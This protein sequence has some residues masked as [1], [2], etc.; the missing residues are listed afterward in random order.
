MRDIQFPGRSVVHG[1]NGAAATSTPLATLTAIDTLRAGG[2]AVDAAIAACA[3]QCVAEPMSTG[4]GGDCFMLY[5][6][7]GAGPVAGFNGSGR[8]PAGLTAESLLDRGIGQIDPDG[9]ESVTVPGAVDAWCAIL[10]AH[11]TM[12]IDRVLQ[13]AIAC[14]EEGFTVGEV[15]RRLWAGR[16]DGLRGN[17]AAAALYLKDGALPETGDIWHSP[18]LGRTLRAIAERG[19]DGFYAGPVLD[20]MLAA[21][22]AAGGCHTEEDFAGQ[23]HEPVAPLE[24]GYRGRTVLE[25]PPNGGGITAQIML[26]ILEGFDLAAL[27]PVG[28]ERLHLEMEAQRLAYAQRD[29]FVGDPR[30]S[31]VPVE[32]LLSDDFAAGL[33]NGIRRDRAMDAP[34]PVEM[35][36]HRDTVYLTVVDRDL[37]CVS[38]IN[39]VYWSFGSCIASEE[40]GVVFQNRGAGFVVEP[41]HP[42][43]VGPRKRPLHTIIP[44]MVLNDGRCELAF[45][46]MGGPFQPVGQTHV[47][48]NL[49]DFGMDIQQAI[50]CP[51][52]F[53]DGG[54]IIAERGVPEAAVAGLRALGHMVVPAE[55]PHGGGQ[56]ILIDRE[57]G[58]LAAGS[59]PRR[60]G[61]A[62]GY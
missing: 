41:G 30:H 34:P 50:D 16:L 57:R 29:A 32:R 4:I 19:R 28:A 46:V 48:T 15:T 55:S 24:S 1:V 54:A 38:L 51:R 43:C 60:D 12:G 2:N 35:P 37:N 13:P 47:V 5:Q 10:D 56:G 33:R 53:H 8:S 20:A 23:R 9:V 62:L 40:T 44:G 59:D 22:K 18:A 36:Q 58:V 31:N 61:C 11:G 7:G 49:W 21:L 26:N 52:V 14:A 42:N 39:S 27:D 25:I 17:E 6:K 3:V 45:G